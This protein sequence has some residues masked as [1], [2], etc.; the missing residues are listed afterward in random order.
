MNWRYSGRMGRNHVCEVMRPIMRCDT[1]LP[2]WTFDLLYLE[3]NPCEDLTSPLLPQ[4][5]YLGLF[6]ISSPD[7][8][9]H[10]GELSQYDSSLRRFCFFCASFVFSLGSDFDVNCNPVL[11]RRRGSERNSRASR[12]NLGASKN[13]PPPFGSSHMPLSRRGCGQD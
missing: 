9:K 13:L 10:P 5:Q 4:H 12:Q 11:H 7:H 2:S 6:P 3:L 8:G 1:D